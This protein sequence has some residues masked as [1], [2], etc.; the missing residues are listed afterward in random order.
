MERMTKTERTL[1]GTDGIRGRAG[2]YPLTAEMALKLGQVAADVLLNDRYGH[3]WPKVV[4]G[5]DTRQSG[6]MFEAAVAA[7]LNSRGVDVRLAGVVPTPAV[8]MLIEETD[9]SFGIVISASHNP[10]EDN[11]IKFFGGDGYKLDDSIELALELALESPPSS[12]ALPGIGRTAPLDDAAERYMHFVAEHAGEPNLLA[13]MKIALDTA[14]GAASE[15]SPAILSALGAEVHTFHNQP[16]GININAD[17]GCTHAGRIESLVRET[18]AYVGVSHDG[19]AD[20]VLLCDETGSVL[21]GDEMMAIAAIS[22]LSEGSLRNETLVATQMSNMGLDRAVEEAGGKVLRT[23]VGD[24][25]V[26][27]AMRKHDFNLG[28]EQSGHF[29]FRDLN[30]TGDGIISAVQIL[31]IVQQSGKPLSELRQLMK[32]F[33]QVQKNIRVSQKPDLADVHS[34]QEALAEVHRGLGERGRVLMRYSGT[35]PLLRILVEG[36]D[37]DA[38]GGY[39]ERIAEAAMESIGAAK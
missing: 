24:R 10:F 4:I 9:A 29:V 5:K 11:G 13:G 22:M 25:Y 6:D 28:G 31:S 7:G 39:I 15:T 35:E 21:D 30:T 17:C 12:T 23:K 32:P 38:I 34:V 3:H 20:R 16:N 18:G 26:V 37:A 33:P 19:D 2:V 27:E 36:E 8:A 1:F 14:N